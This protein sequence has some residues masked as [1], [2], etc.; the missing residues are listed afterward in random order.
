MK[1]YVV[2]I[3]KYVWAEN[4]EAVK[5]IVEQECSKEDIKRDNRCSVVQIVEQEFGSIGSRKVL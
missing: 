3:E 4:D 5:E 1:R 2:Q